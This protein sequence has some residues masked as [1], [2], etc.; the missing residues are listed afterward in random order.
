M[1]ITSLRTCAIAFLVVAGTGCRDAKQSRG[2]SST[3]TDTPPE[4]VAFAPP[5]EPVTGERFVSD[6]EL[7]AW[8]KS[9]GS[10]QWFALY[11]NDVKAGYA[12][13][14][15]RPTRDGEPGGYMTHVM[16]TLSVDG[17]DITLE[18]DSYYEGVPPYRLVETSSTET[19]DAGRS[20]HRYVVHSDR[21]EVHG[22]VDGR[23]TAPRALPPTCEVLE[24][25]LATSI[26][27]PTRLRVGQTASYCNFDP[28]DEATE[29]ERATVVAIDK[30]RIAGVDTTV[31]E[32]DMVSEGEQQSMRVVIA[33][34]ATTLEV[35]HGA[36]LRLEA[37]D[38]TTAMSDVRGMT[39]M[40]SMVPIATALGNPKART[41][42]SLVVSVPD[43]FE[44]PTGPNQRVSRRDDGRYL[45]DITRGPGPVVTADE[46]R[47]ALATTSRFDANHPAIVARARALTAGR[48]DR[49]DQV[50]SISRWVYRTMDA[51]LAT[52]LSTASQVLD[53]RAGDCTEYTL[54]FVALA[55]AAGIPAR[56]VGGVTYAGDE[57]QA[58]GWHAWAEV[59]I[60][61]RWVQ[62]D[63][64]WDEPVANATHL[65]LG[66][67]ENDE[68]SAAMSALEL[69]VP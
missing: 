66:A 49:T 13:L 34:G 32:I 39:M 46:R 65:K 20:M 41:E 12:V 57:L 68:S 21:I 1:S 35:R 52:N 10:E 43:G 19:T 16:A 37:T 54:L 18:E 59:D 42:L 44:I 3:P 47:A 31:A 17:D 38:K 55:R 30:R 60:D 45:V 56:E 58:F 36:A 33:A 5:G 64:S 2:P 40:D 28:N 51:S 27:D 61:G 8:V 53:R 4:S 11:L 69:A 6:A 9:D 14:I 50:R 67:G 62:V 29:R 15:N 48:S 7:A 23:E 26:A 63:P 22:I 25:S 24:D